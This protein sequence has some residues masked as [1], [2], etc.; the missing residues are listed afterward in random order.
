[1]SLVSFFISTSFSGKHGWL[2]LFFF[3]TCCID[4][5][6]SITLFSISL[7]IVSS[8]LD[9]P[10]CSLIFVDFS[11]PFVPPFVGFSFPLYDLLLAFLFLYTLPTNVNKCNFYYFIFCLILPNE[12]L[13]FCDDTHCPCVFL[14][15]ID[16]SPKPCF[17]FLY[18]YIANYGLITST[19]SHVNSF[20]KPFII[21]ISKMSLYGQNPFLR[22]FILSGLYISETPFSARSLG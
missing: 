4:V 7:C 5:I 14:A 8:K 18:I 19:H 16:L 13:V 17:I 15:N 3:F 6:C 10:C 21:F 9:S 2:L 22:I 11:L 1:V 12:S 20:K